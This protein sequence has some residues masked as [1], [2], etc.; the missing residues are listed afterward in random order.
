MP[1]HYSNDSRYGYTMIQHPRAAHACVHMKS[2][3]R[4]VRLHAPHLAGCYVLLQ[5]ACV[6]CP[7]IDVA[8][9]FLSSRCWVSCKRCL[10]LLGWCAVPLCVGALRLVRGRGAC[11]R[12]LSS[13][14]C[15]VVGWLQPWQEQQ[16]LA[17]RRTPSQLAPW[18]KVLQP[19][20]VWTSHMTLHNS[21]GKSLYKPPVACTD[22]HR[23]RLSHA[24]WSH[25]GH[26]L[27]TRWS[28]TPWSHPG[29]TLVTLVTHWSP[30]APWAHAGHPGHP[31]HTLV[32]AGHTLVTCCC[33]L[34]LSRSWSSPPPA[35]VEIRF[36]QRYSAP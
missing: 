32:H 27:V 36:R 3:T 13:S 28:L 31:G 11:A 7:S 29:H 30:W 4:K 19:P 18:M 14:M 12:R 35:P 17:E 16:L 9:L 26:T 6:T 21:L 24:R 34:G 10:A 25:P 20:V 2:A 15:A 1:L 8:S 23:C 22:T 5:C 33:S